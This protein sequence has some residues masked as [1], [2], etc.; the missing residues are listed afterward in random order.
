MP[1]AFEMALAVMFGVEEA[2]L[3]Q[4]LI[5]WVQKNKANGT[6]F[7][8]GRYWTYNTAAAFEKLF[9]CWNQ[10]KIYR[11]LDSLEAK[12]AIF[13]GNYN[14]L[15]FDRTK[16][17]AVADELLDG[18]WA[19]TWGNANPEIGTSQAP[20]TGNG[21]TES[22]AAIPDI[23][24]DNKPN[25]NTDVGKPT[26]KPYGEFGNAK[27]SDVEYTK[28]QAEFGADV[29]RYISELDNWVQ[30]KGFQK[31]YK[32]WYATLLKWGR[33]DRKKSTRDAGD[34]YDRLN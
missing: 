12:G 5:F 26:R 7:H 1:I 6:H 14:K 27:L 10:K 24:T 15:A 18:E 19:T 25:V 23:N 29:Q 32:D 9:P 21:I 4:N 31:K 22:G 17:Y 20:I 16:W 13:S 30:A 2:V 8:D 11:L 34:M 28:L 3:L 33:S